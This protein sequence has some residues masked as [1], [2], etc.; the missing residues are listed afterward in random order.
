MFFF[1]ISHEDLVD[2]ILATRNPWRFFDHVEEAI[3]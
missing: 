3:N 1:D 2:Y